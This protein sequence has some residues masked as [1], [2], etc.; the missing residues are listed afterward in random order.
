MRILFI[1][2]LLFNLATH[3]FSQNYDI[4]YPIKENFE[5]NMD[6]YDAKQNKIAYSNLKYNSIESVNGLTKINVLIKKYDTT[7]NVIEQKNYNVIFSDTSLMVDI[8]S[9][10]EEGFNNQKNNIEIIENNIIFP[11]YLSAK[12]KL[13]EANLFIKKD[14]KTTSNSY[15]I[16]LKNRTIE[17]NKDIEINGQIYNCVRINYN[18]V[19]NFSLM[20]MSKSMTFEIMD[21]FYS[22]I[23]LIKSEMFNE[24]GKLLTT[25]ILR[26]YK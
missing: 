21:Y 10:A 20:S 25:T 9:F 14:T 18:M 12:S 17:E 1:T 6:I 15:E 3:I 26:N 24:N 13:P 5:K 23:G 16:I 7:N 22:N 2:F 4:I 19:I 11:K 8:K